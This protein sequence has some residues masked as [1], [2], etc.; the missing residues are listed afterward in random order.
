MEHYLVGY[1]RA[2]LAYLVEGFYDV[3]PPAVLRGSGPD[4]LT[5]VELELIVTGLPVIDVKTWRENTL[6]R[7][8]QSLTTS[9]NIFVNAFSFATNDVTVFTR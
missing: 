3:L 4:A 6:V 8:T 5:A 9:P 7:T 1:C 2:E